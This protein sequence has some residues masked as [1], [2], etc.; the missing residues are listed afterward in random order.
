MKILQL[1]LSLGTGGAERLVVGL[2]N[3]FAANVNDE[4]VLV[5]ILDD[6]IPGNIHYWPEV[7]PRVRLVNLHC[8][9]ALQVKAVWRA[10][11]TI[12]KE[13]PDVVHSHTN[14]FLL[15]FPA[16]FLKGIRYFQT[17][18]TL[19]KRQYANAEFFKKTIMTYL[20]SHNKVKPVTISQTCHQSYME[21]YKLNNDICIDNGSE[22]MATSAS[23][24]AVKKEIEKLKKNDETT[25]FIH[26]ARHHPAKNHNRLF[27][28]FMRLGKE[29]R[30]FILLVLGDNYGRLVEDFQGNQHFFFVGVK[31][32]VGDYMANADFFVLSSDVEGLPMTL[33]EAMS[34]GVVPI[35][36][37]AGGVTDVIKNGVNGYLAK[38]FDDE[39]FYSMI[40]QAC[41]G[42]KNI[43]SEIV[44]KSYEERF[45]MDVCA[46]NYYDLYRNTIK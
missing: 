5:T 25:V 16:L 33:L 27:R 11:N 15:F 22:S 10:F 42:R 46:R 6:A 9:S 2:C 31:S 17:I 32:N 23:F 7:A 44:R 4:V 21:T 3:R 28:A 34:M 29:N 12:R 1:A 24:N 41:L 18:H 20:Y 14:V 35:S 8:Q 39:T 38:D 36:T 45:S 19:A 40:K 43:S 37:P 26:V 30:N 13:A